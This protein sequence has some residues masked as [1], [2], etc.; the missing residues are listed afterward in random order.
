MHGVNLR[1]AHLAE[2]RAS[3][4]TRLSHTTCPLSSRSTSCS[5][6]RPFSPCRLTGTVGVNELEVGC[7]TSKQ[8][9]HTQQ[10]SGSGCDNSDAVRDAPAPL[11][12]AAGDCGVLPA[13][14]PLFAL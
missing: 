8:R 12:A 10:P 5:L 9:G 2:P 14:E 4:S 3:T 6:Q 11:W 7:C 13:S 1:V